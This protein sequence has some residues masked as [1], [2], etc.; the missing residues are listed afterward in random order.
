MT[1]VKLLD[2]RG[3]MVLAW[4][5]W[6]SGML[7]SKTWGTLKKSKMSMLSNSLRDVICVDVCSIPDRRVCEV[8]VTR[9]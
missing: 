2:R 7:A 5:S 3:D 4:L 6:C 9:S 1:P 8:R